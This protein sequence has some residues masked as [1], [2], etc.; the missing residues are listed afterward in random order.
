MELGLI[1]IG[2]FIIITTYVEAKSDNSILSKESLK[3]FSRTIIGGYILGL[4]SIITALV[5]WAF[6]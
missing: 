2:I 5:F 1:I 6:Y 3:I 4:A